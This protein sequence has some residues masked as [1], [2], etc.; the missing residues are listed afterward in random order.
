MKK[1]RLLIAKWLL[2]PEEITLADFEAITGFGV[3]SVLKEANET[4]KTQLSESVRKLV[5]E[6]AKNHL[7][8]LSPT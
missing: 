4:M 5:A 8:H 2:A 3:S 7:P 6:Y 1:L